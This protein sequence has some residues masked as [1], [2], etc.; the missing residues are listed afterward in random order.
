MQVDIFYILITVSAWVSGTYML[1]VGI[2][3]RSML[4]RTARLI[5]IALGIFILYDFTIYMGVLLGYFPL[6]GYGLLLRPAVPVLIL[7]VMFLD[8]ILRPRRMHL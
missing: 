8:M 3:H 2:E 4:S 7:D 5:Y 1:V 6:I